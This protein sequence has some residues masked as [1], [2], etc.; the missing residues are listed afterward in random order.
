MGNLIEWRIFSITSENEIQGVKFR[1]RLRKYAIEQELNL[2][3]END[4]T[5]QKIV[6][7]AIPEDELNEAIS[8]RLWSFVKEVDSTSKITTEMVDV[9]NPVLSKLKCNDESRY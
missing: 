7:F 1:G 5:N 2:L 8:A 6:R 4:D 3:T 9:V